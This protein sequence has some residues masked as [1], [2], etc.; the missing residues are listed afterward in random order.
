MFAHIERMIEERGEL[1]LKICRL[2][3]WLDLNDHNQETKMRV[4]MYEQLDIMK[5]YLT[6]LDSRIEMEMGNG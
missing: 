2:G 1:H 5:K 4:L 6:V 3:F